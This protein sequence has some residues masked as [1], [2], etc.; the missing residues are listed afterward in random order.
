MDVS[1]NRWDTINLRVE[2]LRVFDDVIELSS[3]A[4][5]KHNRLN[6]LMVGEVDEEQDDLHAIFRTMYEQEYDQE[7]V[8]AI[9]QLI[10]YSRGKM[11]EALEQARAKDTN[12]SHSCL[13]MCQFKVNDELIMRC[14][15]LGLESGKFYIFTISADD[16][17]HILCAFT[18][19]SIIY[20]LAYILQVF[21][22]GAEMLIH[23]LRKIF[24]TC[25]IS[26]SSSDD[27]AFSILEGTITQYLESN[28][29]TAKEWRKAKA[30][31]IAEDQQNEE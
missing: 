28:A 12:G 1:I 24:S 5:L 4:F 17:S 20:A 19:Y 25:S 8:A 7:V 27:E 22:D 26:S 30:E 29:E 14:A 15:L 16:D 13:S 6:S 23:T 11:N 31:W 3:D 2:E 10:P 18:M 21:D 9:E